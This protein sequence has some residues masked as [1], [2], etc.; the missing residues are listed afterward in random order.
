MRIGTFGISVVFSFLVCA[1]NEGVPGAPRVF[2]Y[3]RSRDLKS[4]SYSPLKSPGV[5]GQ[6]QL[7][8][9]KPNSLPSQKQ[10]RQEPNTDGACGKGAG[11]CAPGYCCSEAVRFYWA[12]FS[13]PF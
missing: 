6:P 9:L 7:L 12:A 10:R 11:S 2:G 13:I 3:G 4:Q 8:P 1:H 5:S